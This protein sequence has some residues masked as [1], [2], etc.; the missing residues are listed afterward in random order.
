MWFIYST[1]AVF[2]G[3]MLDFLFGDPN[4]W[5]HPICLIGRLISKT[6]KILREA[7][8]ISIQKERKQGVIL[9]V[10]VCLISTAVPTVLLVIAYII[11]PIAG[12][13]LE[14]FLCW[15]LLAGK[16][17]YTESMKVANALETDGLDAGRYAVSM[18]VG[19]DT[20]ELSIEGV[21]KAT[22]ET[23]AENTSDGIVAP[24]FY[25]LILGAPFGFLYKSINTMDSMVGYKNDKYINFGRMAAKLDDAANFIP[26]RISGIC[27]I[28]GAYLG[29]DYSGENA[30]KIFKRD[31]LKHASPNS[32]QTESVMAGA[33]GVQLAG[34]ANYFG[35]KYEK[36]F[37][38]DFTRNI[39]ISDIKKAGRLMYITSGVFAL[40]GFVV[41]GLVMLCISMVATFIIM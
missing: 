36:P 29:K 10:V 32:A 17:L 15:F 39:E 38:G 23:V 26:S 13:A 40:A 35:K 37:I 18:I 14:S 25:M 16:C 31:R 27:M 30:V 11:H 28:I 21:I 33:L 7:K 4:V 19:R 34:D 6:E 24:L 41:K 1:L 3:L 5:W 20:N 12:F 8:D 22:V 2:V 9:V